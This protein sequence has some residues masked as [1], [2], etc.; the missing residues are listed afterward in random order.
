MMYF[1]LEDVHKCMKEYSKSKSDCIS[2]VINRY[3]LFRVIDYYPSGGLS[4]CVGRYNTIDDA[5]KDIVI[6]EYYEDY[7]VYDRILDKVV[8]DSD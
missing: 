5:K 7:Y 1:T 4:D 2:N 8:L 3:M 6:K